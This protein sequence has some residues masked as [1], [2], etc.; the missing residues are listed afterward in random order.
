[1]VDASEEHLEELDDWAKTAREIGMEE[2]DLDP[3]PVDY[4]LVEY[5]KVNE[6]S[7]YSGMP[8]KYPHWRHGM[9]Y[10]RSDKQDSYN[11]GRIYE[12]V[13][14]T[15]PSLAYLQEA[16]SSANQKLVMAHVVAH[17]D[18]F[19]NNIW[20]ADRNKDAMEM[21][22]RHRKKIQE[23]Q[24]EEGIE[25][26]EEFID[27]VMSIE[28]R[29]DYLRDQ[30]DP[31]T[32]EEEIER[33]EEEL[34]E[35][36]TAGD[37]E[38]HLEDIFGPEYYDERREEKKERIEELKGQSKPLEPHQDLMQFLADESDELEDWQEDIIRMIREESLYFFPQAYTK[39]INEGWAAFNH[40]RIMSKGYEGNDND[41]NFTTMDELMEM[42]QHDARQHADNRSNPYKIGKRIFE[43]IKERFDEGKY[44][45]DWERE[46]RVDLRENWEEH[47]REIGEA[48]KLDRGEEQIKHVRRFKNDMQFIQEYLTDELVEDL[49]L[50]KQDYVAQADQWFIS[51]RDPDEIRDRL[52]FEKIN[53]GQPIVDVADSDYN[54]AG[55]LKLIH[56]HNGI[57]LH[58]GDAHGTMQ[59][60][61]E[62]WGKPV[63]LHTVFQDIEERWEYDW[64]ENDEEW[65]QFIERDITEHPVEIRYDGEE[66]EYEELDDEEVD[67]VKIEKDLE[68]PEEVELW[69]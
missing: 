27:T 60:I 33:L 17:S 28:R 62:L 13:I 1:M 16:N 50:Y 61:Q 43:D 3:H 55:E 63:V 10:E 9:Q 37:T 6:A 15:D 12:M 4:A 30:R 58:Q 45:E 19:K 65:K 40:E 69:M 7:A 18:F 2:F 8:V 41:Y 57:D 32:I 51:S 52:I 21:F 68:I 42:W 56:R 46:T 67:E 48:D 44:G 29:V 59:R 39:T 64:D 24:A 11:M 49:N 5:Y 54:N 36:E 25:D 66:F 47:L 14:N 23:Y 22:K 20:L 38:P 35:M 31:R 26:V 34:D 53:G